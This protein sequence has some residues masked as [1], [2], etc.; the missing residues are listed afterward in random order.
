LYAPR[1]TAPFMFTLDAH[2]M[3]EDTH[4]YRLIRER[5][6]VAD[7]GRAVGVMASEVPADRF[8]EFVAWLYPLLGHDDR[9]NMTRIWQAVMPPDAF[10]GATALV[11]DAIGD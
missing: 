9:E 3:K 2:L 5:V 8:P 10:V 1:A 11:Q 6:S 7:Q 4:L